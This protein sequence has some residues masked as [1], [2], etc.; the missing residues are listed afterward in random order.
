MKFYNYAMIAVGLTLLFEWAGM[1]ITSNLLSYFGI[2]TGVFDFV[3]SA[4]WVSII[5]ISVLAGGI[6]VGVITRS[7]P[8]NYIIL[9]IILATAAVFVSSFLGIYIYAYAN[10]PSWIANITGFIIIMLTIGF[11]ISVYEH[12]R[13]TD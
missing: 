12:F 13:G 2:G 1:H 7:N 5:G 8:E 3:S 10:F 9:P 6:I 11:G 4:T